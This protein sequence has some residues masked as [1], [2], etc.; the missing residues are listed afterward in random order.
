MD[1]KNNLE[2]SS[3][4]EFQPATNI[5]IFTEDDS[6]SSDDKNISPD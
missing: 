1:E 5:K 3:E 2:E 6:E 4:Y